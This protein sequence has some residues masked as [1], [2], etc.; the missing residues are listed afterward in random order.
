MLISPSGNIGTSSW[1]APGGFSNA[2][3]QNDDKDGEYR[4][5]VGKTS[6]T[7][8]DGQV[9][10]NTPHFRVETPGGKVEFDNQNSSITTQPPGVPAHEI[11]MYGED[12]PTS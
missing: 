3:P 12:V 8:K 4:L 7:I 9:L 1:G 6:I 10:I 11:Q 5:S 2:N